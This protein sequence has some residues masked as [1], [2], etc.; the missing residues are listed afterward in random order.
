MGL[1]DNAEG[2]AA[3][4]VNVSVAGR[5]QDCETEHLLEDGPGGIGLVGGAE[6]EGGGGGGEDDVLDAETGA[7]GEGVEGEIVAAKGDVGV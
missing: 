4:V 5:G 7:D 2:A 6:A 3:D 1:V